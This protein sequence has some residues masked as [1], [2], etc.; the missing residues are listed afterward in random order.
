MNTPGQRTSSVCPAGNPSVRNHASLRQNPTSHSRWYTRVLRYTPLTR[1]AVSAVGTL[2]CLLFFNSTTGFS[3]ISQ[4][5]VSFGTTWNRRKKGPVDWFECC[6][7]FYENLKR[8]SGFYLRAPVARCD[9]KFRL[10]FATRLVTSFHVKQFFFP[11]DF[12]NEYSI[13]Q[14]SNRR[15]Q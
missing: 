12:H 8:P 9:L 10:V 2:A 1:F 14:N 13:H 11:A 6:N 5:F 15:E 3:I 4:Q 7:E